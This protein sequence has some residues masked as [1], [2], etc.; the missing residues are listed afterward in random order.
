MNQDWEIKISICLDKLNE[1][2]QNCMYHLG[3]SE[4]VLAC[5]LNI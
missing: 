5:I 2:Y 3:N 1:T 4:G